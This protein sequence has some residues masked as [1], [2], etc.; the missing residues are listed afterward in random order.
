[1]DERTLMT[2][3]IVGTVITSALILLSIFAVERRRLER[4]VA[5][6]L[7]FV[8]VVTRCLENDTLSSLD[9]LHDLYRAHFNHSMRGLGDFEELSQLIRQVTLRVAVASHLKE[10]HKGLP[11]LKTLLAANEEH[12]RQ[13]HIRIPFSDAPSPER[14]LLEDILEL[15]TND[16]DLV[17][18]KLN[19]LGKAV[20]IR[21]DTIERLGTES[22]QSLVW[23]KW[24][25]AGTVLFSLVSIALAIWTLK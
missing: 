12:V 8:D 23:A 14:Q 5:L 3:L 10:L 7:S 13:E 20:R 16:K 19:E 17:R 2:L 15:T 6:Q 24:G 4:H 11:R 18:S 1:M 25:L 22:H 21:Q 9:D